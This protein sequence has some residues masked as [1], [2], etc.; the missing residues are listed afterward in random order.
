MSLGR[1]FRASLT[2]GTDVCSRMLTYAHVCSRM[3]INM[4]EAVLAVA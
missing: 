1:Q 3:Q 2:T 4:E